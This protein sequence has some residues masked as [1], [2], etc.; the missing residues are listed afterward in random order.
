MGLEFVAL[1][2]QKLESRINQVKNNPKIAPQVT[3]TTYRKLL[4]HKNISMYYTIESDG[5]YILLLW[6]NRQDPKVLKKALTGL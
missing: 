5:V 1:F 4:I 3:S 6:D 2:T